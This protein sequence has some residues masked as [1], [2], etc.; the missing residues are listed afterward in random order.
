MLKGLKH[1]GVNEGGENALS[2]K[3]CGGEG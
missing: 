1:E 2:T 3:Q